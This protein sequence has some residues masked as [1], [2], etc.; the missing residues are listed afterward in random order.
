ML[1]RAEKSTEST[2]PPPV[3]ECTIDVIVATEVNVAAIL[4]LS[5]T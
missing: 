2:P 1:E 5:V 4:L 3:P